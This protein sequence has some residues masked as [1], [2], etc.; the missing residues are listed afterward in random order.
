MSPRLIMVTRVGRLTYDHKQAIVLPACLV[1]T[2][3]LILIPEE[4]DQT[5][6]RSGLHD[7]FVNESP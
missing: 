7:I 3:Q 1:R 5:L 6:N 4:N 2:G